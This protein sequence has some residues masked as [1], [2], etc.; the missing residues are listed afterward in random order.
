M[1]IGIFFI[2]IGEKYF[3]LYKD[4][5]ESFDKNFLIN[6]NKHYFL[7]CDN[8]YDYELH[9]DESR[10]IVKNEEWPAPILKRYEYFLKCD[11]ENMDYLF[12]INGNSICQHKVNDNDV[13]PLREHNWLCACSQQFRMLRNININSYGYFKDGLHPTFKGGFLGGRKKEF[14]E[15]CE[16]CVEMIK[17]DF[18]EYGFSKFYDEVYFNTY[19]LNKHIKKIT[20]NIFSY[21]NFRNNSPKIVTRDKGKLFGLEFLKKLKGKDY[22][23]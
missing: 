9:D 1:N 14:I 23:Y 18:E 20:P 19:V 11:T 2:G 3:S 16:D 15:M 5:K 12:F 22:K 4:F 7:I 17:K 10:I 21:F 8:E 13:I 6:H